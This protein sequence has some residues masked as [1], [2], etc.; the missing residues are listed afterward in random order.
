MLNTRVISNTTARVTLKI[1]IYNIQWCRWGFLS[2]ATDGT[3]CPGVD[4]DSENKYQDT[5]GGKDGRRPY[6]LHSAK[7]RENPEALNFRVSK[8]LP[9]PVAGKLYLYYLLFL[10]HFIVSVFKHEVERFIR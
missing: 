7:S 5:P 1:N 4:S 6:H 3:M 10:S 8:G 2:V 9:R